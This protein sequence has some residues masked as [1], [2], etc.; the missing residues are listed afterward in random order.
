MEKSTANSSQAISVENGSSSADSHAVAAVEEVTAPS[1]VPP[2]PV[3][4][5]LT[6]RCTRA[7]LWDE[8]FANRAIEGY[9]QFMSLKISFE[10]WS[11]TKLAAPPIIEKVWQQHLLDVTHYVSACGA[12]LIHHNAEDA[13]PQPTRDPDFARRMRS[14]EFATQDCKE[15]DQEIW[16]FEYHKRSQ[17]DQDVEE[18]PA[19]KRQRTNESSSE[20]SRKDPIT[21]FVRATAQPPNDLYFKV[22][23]DTKMHRVFERFHVH[24]ARREDDQQEEAFSF[25]IGG[26]L[27]RPDDTANT[28]GLCH[29]DMV[30]AMRCN[31]VED[32]E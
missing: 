1:E 5:S 14:T 17:E 31:A 6:R 27:I 20:P 21:F 7:F 28:L 30:C 12:H 19:A 15:M 18:A 23:P 8:S 25:F 2:F 10:D 22:R 9:Q 3:P 11:S 29:D 24:M 16:S 32:V 26:R 13:L 4:P